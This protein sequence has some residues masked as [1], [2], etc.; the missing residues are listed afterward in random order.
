M[1]DRT[2]LRQRQSLS[3]DEKIM[4]SQARIR[5]WYEHWN[6]QVYVAFSG[7]K[8]SLVLIHLARDFYP[9]IQACFINTGL[10]WPE[11]IQHVKTIS[12]V[13]IVRPQHDFKWC[14]E[15]YG[16]PIVS[17]MVSDKIEQVRMTKNPM[18]RELWLTGRSGARKT[19][20]RIPKKW[21]YLVDAPFKISSHCCDYLKKQ[22]AIR[23]ERATGLHPMLGTLAVESMMRTAEYV[24]YGCNAYDKRRPTSSPIAFWMEQD[25]L[26]YL[27]R[28]NL[29]IAPI[30]GRISTIAGIHAC[31]GEQRTGCVACPFGQHHLD[32][33]TYQ[34]MAR[35]HPKL[36]TWI[37]DDLNMRQVLEYSKV[38]YT[39]DEPL[40]I[41]GQPYSIYTSEKL[42]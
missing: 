19:M 39:P 33:N 38:K 16:Y 21:N 27:I 24:H 6:G 28:Y 15:K 3:L 2:T 26:E 30:Y 32:P 36:L 17:K 1:M 41:P 25:V 12:K 31:T 18:L 13:D 42:G 11:I 4:L 22:P 37:L 20:F 5:D 34:R 29:S 8:D 40:R 35:T 10:E 7:G 9:E 14:C 23:Y